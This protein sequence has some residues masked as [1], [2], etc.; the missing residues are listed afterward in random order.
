MFKEQ[1]SINTEII[2]V[3]VDTLNNIL[4]EYKPKDID[5]D[6]LTIDVEGLELVILKS[7]DFERFAPKMILVEDLFFY[8]QEN[9]IIDYHSSE[10]YQFL[11]SKNYVFVA[12]T[13]YT[14]LFKRV[15]HH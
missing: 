11:K 2:K 1:N 3:K 13:W 8:N 9:D 7:I 14:L 12:K 15:A 6:F 10:L 4:S 5:I